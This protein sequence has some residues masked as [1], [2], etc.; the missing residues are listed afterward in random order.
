MQDEPEK[1]GQLAYDWDM[2]L[3]MS[4]GNVQ[5]IEQVSNFWEGVSRLN[6]GRYLWER[7]TIG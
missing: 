7:N 1:L 3:I 4:N 5:T 2:R 6:S